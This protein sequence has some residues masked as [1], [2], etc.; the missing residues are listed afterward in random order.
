MDAS[1]DVA[2]NAQMQRVV[3]E[4]KDAARLAVSP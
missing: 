4:C 2:A 3:R 1:S